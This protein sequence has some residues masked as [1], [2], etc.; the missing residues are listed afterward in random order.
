MDNKKLLNGFLKKIEGGKESFNL[1]AYLLYKLE[2]LLKNLELIEWAIDEAPDVATTFWDYQ[3]NKLSERFFKH[4]TL[5]EDIEDVQKAF[6][7]LHRKNLNIYFVTLISIYESFLNY[8]IRKLSKNQSTL[9]LPIRIG[10]NEYFINKKG[11]LSLKKKINSNGIQKEIEFSGIQE[12]LW[13]F[14]NLLKTNKP[15]ER[16]KLNKN[17]FE[18]YSILRNQILH[19]DE[20]I[21]DLNLLP[22]Y[23]EV[24]DDIFAKDNKILI[25]RKF[26]NMAVENLFYFCL[27][28][29]IAYE[30]RVNVNVK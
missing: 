8:I 7:S 1:G 13:C 4:F 11:N 23:D 25:S 24:K 28:I 21:V 20:E 10:K 3:E 12:K 14:H 29:A 30:K 5:L 18:Y 15:K 26:F 17:D 9:K 16:R 2:E 22:I 6:E 19:K 27:D